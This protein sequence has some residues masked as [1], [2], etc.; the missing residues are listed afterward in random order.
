MAIQNYIKPALCRVKNL[1]SSTVWYFSDVSP[2]F[3]ELFEKYK[4]DDIQFNQEKGVFQLSNKEVI[5]WVQSQIDSN[6]TNSELLISINSINTT[7]SIWND[8]DNAITLILSPNFPIQKKS[9]TEQLLIKLQT[10]FAH[11]FG[12]DF[13][14]AICLLLSKTLALDYVFVGKLHEN[15]NMIEVLGGADSGKAMGSLTYDLKYTPCSNVFSEGLCFYP[16]NIQDLFPADILLQ[17]MDAEAYLG[18]LIYSKNKKPLGLLVGL[19]K[20]PIVNSSS[21]T[22][23]FSLFIERIAAE[24]QRIEYENSLKESQ[25]RLANI[26]NTM[27]E[28]VLVYNAKGE[29]IYANA[30]VDSMISNEQQ[31]WF[32]NPKWIQPESVFNA[33]FSKFTKERMPVYVTLKT[34]LPQQNVQL[35]IKNLLNNSLT[36]LMLNSQPIFEENS[37]KVEFVVLTMNNITDKYNTSKQYDIILQTSIDG[38]WIHDANGKILEVN[39]AYCNLMGY[40]REEMLKKSISD[41]EAKESK[42]EVIQHI[43]QVKEK[44]Y[45]R[46]ETQHYHKNGSLV[47][48][49]ISVK[50][51]HLDKDKAVVFARD[52]TERKRFEKALKISEAN[53]KNLFDSMPNGYYKSTPNGRFIDANPAFIHMLGYA[54][55]EDLKK[56]D[57]RHDLYVQPS[58]RDD[59]LVLNPDFNNQVE[60]YRLK[61]KDGKIIWLEEDARYI[62]NENGEV[63]YHEGICKDISDRVLFE[64]ELKKRN[65]EL[66]RFVYSVSHDLRAPIVSVLGLINLAEDNNLNFESE[67]NQRDLFQ[68]MKKS[69]MKL[70][71]F[72]AEILEYSQNHHLPAKIENVNIKAAIESIL[73]SH[74]YTLPKKDYSLVLDIQISD[75]FY[76]DKARFKIIMNN[77]LSNALK[78]LDLSKE[79]PTVSITVTSD[80]ETIQI[81]VKDNGIGIK[82]YLIPKLFS[83]FYRATSKSTGSGLGL[84]IAKETVER[85]GGTIQI[86]SEFGEGTEVTVKLPKLNQPEE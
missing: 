79:K 16:S 49:E 70:D 1:E 55:L 65:D 53:F 41:L 7:I 76:T 67:S 21:V 38:F 46:F 28:G 82:S 68:M 39:E 58:E 17:Q 23:V 52:I 54:D 57:I 10:D 18:V 59:M 77:L 50:S 83:M 86:V 62:R 3:I 20:S 36:W 27:A 26:V 29:V 64:N 74:E 13:F 35:G 24:M 40:T 61:R 43:K 25:N 30:K 71:D 73:E 85:L 9:P 22:S 6:F 75:S 12:K 48:L 66:N 5:R 44:G 15:Q 11:L 32:A 84:Y 63:I 8:K 34:G 78:Y 37:R 4:G 60:V 56:V 33:D 81:S 47:D 51:V 2:M 45:D 14:D 42:K 69:M 80:L 72:I 19:N 31:K